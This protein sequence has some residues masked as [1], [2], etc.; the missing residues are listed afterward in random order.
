MI[1]VDLPAAMECVEKGC[2]TRLS[3]KLALTAGGTLVG[4]PPTGHNW[5]ISI[6][7]ANG[8]LVC[9]CPQHHVVIEKPHPNSDL[10]VGK[11]PLP[12]RH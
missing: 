6:N 7:Q 2:E 3:I 4:R 8:V 11:L 1:T 10:L 9:R 5:Q 12:S